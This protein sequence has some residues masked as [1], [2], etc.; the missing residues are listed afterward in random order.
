MQQR[1]GGVGINGERLHN[2]SVTDKK[3]KDDANV[4]F[5]VNMTNDHNDA[6]RC[7]LT[8][9][10]ERSWT[11]R[12]ASMK[13]FT[14]ES[15]LGVRHETTI[16]TPDDHCAPVQHD[17]IDRRHSSCDDAQR[18]RLNTDPGSPAAS[19]PNCRDSCLLAC[20]LVLVTLKQSRCP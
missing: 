3:Q 2:H 4:A 17:V 8:I 6:S 5:G 11:C 18:N 14:V 9:V 12:S 10:V 15:I 19:A 1:R 20:I 13:S 7:M 16:S